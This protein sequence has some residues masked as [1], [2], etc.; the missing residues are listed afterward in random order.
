MDDEEISKIFE[1]KVKTFTNNKLGIN[2]KIPFSFQG[3]TYALQVGKKGGPKGPV[4]GPFYFE[5]VLANEFLIHL[6]DHELSSVDVDE[7]YS[8]LSFKKI[9]KLNKIIIPYN[10]ENSEE[11]KVAELTFK[12]TDKDRVQSFILKISDMDMDMDMDTSLRLASQIVATFLDFLSFKAQL[13]LQVRH[14]DICS[15]KRN[16]LCRR[17][18]TLPFT[19]V[20]SIEETDFTSAISIP[21][22]LMPSLRLFREAISSSKPHYRLLCFFRVWEGALRKVQSKNSEIL[23]ERG[24]VPSRPKR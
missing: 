12:T 3:H 10:L 15:G 7:G 18:L 5:F 4:S 23:K 11:E 2:V 13:P 1:S 8:N 20:F 17:Y 6:S 14:I 21:I 19:S 16:N 9:A 22:S 24:I